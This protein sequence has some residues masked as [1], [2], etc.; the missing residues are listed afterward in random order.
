MSSTSN[1]TKSGEEQPL[2]PTTA[3]TTTDGDSNTHDTDKHPSILHDAFDT[4]V[5]GIPIFFSMLSWV[6]M[7]TTDSALLG[8]VSSQALAAAALSDLVR[9]F[10]NEI[11]KIMNMHHVTNS[12]VMCKNLFYV[13]SGPCVP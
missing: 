1:S 10:L 7:K 9:F 12:C 13:N 5:L 3:T 11:S 8:H 4:V 6:G 2:L